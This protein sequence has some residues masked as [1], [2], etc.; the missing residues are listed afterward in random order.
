M[1]IK[2]M[3]MMMMTMMIMMVTNMRIMTSMLFK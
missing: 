1:T 2:R 3:M